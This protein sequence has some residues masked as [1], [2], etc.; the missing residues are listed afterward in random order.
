MSLAHVLNAKT[1]LYDT[2][3]TERHTD[4]LVGSPNYRHGDSTM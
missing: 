2:L 3:L 1:T 4:V